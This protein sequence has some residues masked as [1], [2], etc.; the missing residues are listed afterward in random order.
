MQPGLCF[1]GW[2][3]VVLFGMMAWKKQL[4][5][6]SEM[7][8]SWVVCPWPGCCVPFLFIYM[9]FTLNPNRILLKFVSVTGQIVEK[10]NRQESLCKVPV[11][12]ISVQIL[13][14]AGQVHVIWCRLI[15]APSKFYSRWIIFSIRNRDKG[16][17]TVHVTKSALSNTMKFKTNTPREI[18]TTCLTRTNWNK[19]WAVL[20]G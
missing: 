5:N 1:T 9:S 16:L 10:F 12:E 19:C 4:L 8:K 13:Q 6:I 3:A 15:W 7:F 14:A 18:D 17:L 2:C 11:N 20:L